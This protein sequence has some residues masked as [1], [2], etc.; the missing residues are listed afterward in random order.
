MCDVE[1]KEVFKPAT[2]AASYGI[3]GSAT[4]A[5]A[6]KRCSVVLSLGNPLRRPGKEEEEQHQSEDSCMPVQSRP[7][8]HVGRR[9]DIPTQG[10]IRARSCAFRL[11]NQVLW[12]FLCRVYKTF[13]PRAKIMQNICHQ[14]FD[15]LDMA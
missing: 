8:G 14:L 15:Q 2:S 1:H 9:V 7:P 5:P 4:R 10:S 13:D 11:E 12:S 3:M 6:C